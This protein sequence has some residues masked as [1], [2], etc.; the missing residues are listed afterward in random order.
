MKL[1]NEGLKAGDLEGVVNKQF[2]IDQFKSKMGD[3]KNILVLGLVVDGQAPAKDLERFAEVGYKSVLDAD[4]TP[5]TLEDGKHRVF[6]E[7]ARSPEVIAQIMAF[8]EDL[9]K[10]TNI[11]EFE[12]TYH[13]NENPT[14]VSA[15]TLGEAIP[16]TPE[17]YEQRV[18]EMRVSEAR[19]F[20]DKYDMME[21][22]IAENIMTVKKTGA[23]HDLKFELHKFGATNEIMKEA[24]AFKI[25]LESISECTHL[26]KYFGPYD[27]TKTNENKFIFTKGDQSALVS[28]SGW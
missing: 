2:S 16:T 28:K 11:E 6:I 5:G 15:G 26:T 9:K 3:D 22:N 24:K 17:A 10:L 8:L 1:V 4:A 23:G 21:C 12:Y 13:K 25:D 7:F 19:H 14:M 18:N 27:I 20:F